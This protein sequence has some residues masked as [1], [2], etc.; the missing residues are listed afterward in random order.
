MLNHGTPASDFR[1][2]LEKN[3]PFDMSQRIGLEE[4]DNE[5]LLERA[6]ASRYRKALFDRLRELLKQFGIAKACK[7]RFRC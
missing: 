5:S 2:F 6:G 7:R 1:K 3:I 4:T